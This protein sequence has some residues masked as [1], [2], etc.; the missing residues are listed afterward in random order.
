MFSLN[1]QPEIMQLVSGSYLKCSRSSRQL[2]QD[3]NFITIICNYYFLSE[4]NTLILAQL[5]STAVY[6]M[7]DHSRVG[8]FLCS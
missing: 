5:Q 8:W 7:V 1:T 4:Q 6:K 3:V 2:V